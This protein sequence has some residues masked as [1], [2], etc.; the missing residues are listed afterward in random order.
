MGSAP[1]ETSGL[2]HLAWSR[3]LAVPCSCLEYLTAPRRASPAPCSFNVQIPFVHDVSVAGG[4][5]LNVITQGQGSDLSLDHHRC[6]GA[7][8][9]G[10]RRALPCTL[11]RPPPAVLSARLRPPAAH[12]PPHPTPPHPTQDGAL[13]Q[14]VHRDQHRQRHARLHLGRPHQQGRLLWPGQ[15][16]L[17]HPGC[18]RPAPAAASLRLRPA[19]LLCG[20]LHWGQGVGGGAVR[21]GMGGSAGHGRAVDTRPHLL[22]SRSARKTSGSSLRCPRAPPISTGRSAPF[23]QPKS[24]PPNL[25]PYPC[26]PLAPP[27][28]LAAS[29]PLA[30]SCWRNVPHDASTL[31][32]SLPQPSLVIFLSSM[33]PTHNIEASK[34]VTDQ[35]LPPLFS[36]P[37]SVP[38]RFVPPKLHRSFLRF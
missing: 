1:G 32:Q 15:R 20:Q 18:R 21:G 38:L 12:P 5:S 3:G 19:A 2:W 30:P 23:R 8:S 14:P 34:H 36:L 35:T 27:T 22:P 31:L 7:R 16:V 37:F 33:P 9:Q 4:T 26:S 10:Y 17:E 24:S 28:S 11:P 6:G 25:D 29:F 13:G